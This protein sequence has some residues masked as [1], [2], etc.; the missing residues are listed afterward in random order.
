LA[1]F[2]AFVRLGTGI[3]GLIHISELAHRRV[4]SVSQILAEGQEVE[5]KILTVD[6]ES[7]R[8]GL[9]LKATQAQPESNKPQA[10]PQP[11]EVRRESAVRKFQGELRG[12]TGSNG[13]GDLFGL[14]L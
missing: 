8:I 6:R 5:V 13:A 9:S 4:T 1:N 10:A 11:E 7:Q 12:G 14:K 3:E 2:G